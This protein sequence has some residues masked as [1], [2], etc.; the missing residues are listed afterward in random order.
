[1]QVELLRYLQISRSRKLGA[2]LFGNRHPEYLSVLEDRRPAP[3]PLWL[4]EKLA[5]KSVD[6][7]PLI[8]TAALRATPGDQLCVETLRIFVSI[9]GAEAG[10]LALTVVATGGVYIAGGIPP[11]R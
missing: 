4:A 11:R 9:L 8:A 3:E 7:T 6:A 10:N 2:G 5:D 1:M